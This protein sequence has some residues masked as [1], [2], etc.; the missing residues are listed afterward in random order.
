MLTPILLP[1]PG[2]GQS[3]DDVHIEPMRRPEKSRPEPASIIE[4]GPGADSLRHSLRVDVDLVLVPVTVTDGTYHPVT[5]LSKHDF[6][7]YEGGERQEIRYFSAEDAPISVGVLLD[8]SRS[9]SNKIEDARE[10]VSEFFKTANPE[11]DYFVITFADSP[12]LLADSTQSTA[13]IQAKLASAKAG[14]QTALLDAVY[15]GISKMRSARHKRRAL[16]IISDGGDNHSRFRASEI[17]RLV[18]ETDVEIYAIGI[19]N[20]FFHTPEERSGK[21]LL[22]EITET[23]GGRAITMSNPAKLPSI[24]R[25]ISLE[26][27]NQYVIGYRPSNGTPDGRWRRIKLEVASS[28]EAISA[29]PPLHLWFR[30]GYLGPEQ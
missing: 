13:S 6:R 8:L 4:T 7:L 3:A 18:Q 16:L 27:R 17:R 20:P 30:R 11:D 19:Y 15:M 24:A 22:T 26:L 12:R 2:W 29:V 10:A 1:A 28:P 23:T 21:R 9:M 5:G 25:T 14:G